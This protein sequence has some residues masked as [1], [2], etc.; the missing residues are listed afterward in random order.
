MTADPAALHSFISRHHPFD[1]LP[2]SALDT[3]S[4]LLDPQ[5]YPADA[6]ILGIDA[7]LD[8]LHIVL[9]GVVDLYS[10]EGRLISRSMPGEI[11][12]A[13]SLLRNGRSAH[14]A[15]AESDTTILRL[16]V[17]VFRQLLERHPSFG[18][19]FDRLRNTPQ[20]QPAANPDNGAAL[21]LAEIRDVMTP[22]PVILPASTSARAAAEVMRDRGI[23]CVLVGTK[24]HLDGILT[25]SDLT[26]RVLAE[27]RDPQLP[28]GEVITPNALSL[29]PGALLFEALLA[30]SSHGIGHLPVVDDGRP[31]GIL[32]RTNLIQRQSLS[33]VAI[34]SD[35]GGLTE[36]ADLAAVV[37]TVPRLL[38]KLVGL[39]VEA[40]R[41]GQLITSVT[42]ALTRRLIQL[43]EA[44]L[45]PPP[46]PYLWLACGSQGRSEQTGVSDQDNC[47]ILDDA[48]VPEEHDAWFAGFARSVSDGLDACG[49][50]YCPG[51]MMATNPR[52]RQ[53]VSVWKG[54]FDGWIA[55]PDPMAQMLA[56]VMFDLRPIHGE[57]SLFAGMHRAT[58]DKARR[59]SIFRAHMTANSLKH[60]PP[61]SLFRGFAL[62]RSGEHKHT[63]DL[64][65]SGVVPI[66]DLA[67]LYAL[68]AGLEPVN[69][70]DRLIAAR[71]TP[72]L[73]PSGGSD[74]LDAYDLIC[75]IRLAHQ[76]RQVRAGQ[77]PDNF[78]APNS[79]SELERNHLRDAFGV[80]KTMQSAISY[81]HAALS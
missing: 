49:Y 74:L 25:T 70:R 65:H 3:L 68:Q 47:L 31:V 64:K 60:T 37:G 50:Y 67:R 20:R 7:P 2:A 10:P 5:S 6:E 22:A 43:A 63:V 72:V 35:I 4:G 1:L 48:F 46:V 69:T 12:A 59:N 32:T 76:A 80:I 28:I 42:D 56:S 71:D 33:A 52:W 61:L 58:L 38:A 53:P 11:F 14:R 24:N 9:D 8:A 54:Y 18:A 51:D 23:S 39:G 36:I 17:T 41:I 19:Y 27:G 26:T 73:S 29:A 75:N 40:H 16:P 21:G 79:L 44:D 55:R 62:I 13:R 77:K 78:M 81:G 30:M 15:V 66:V 45:G 57:E 34:I